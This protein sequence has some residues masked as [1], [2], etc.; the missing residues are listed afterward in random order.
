MCLQVEVLLFL[1]KQDKDLLIKQHLDKLMVSREKAR[2]I[3]A[4]GHRIKSKTNENTLEA[5][6]YLL[7]E[8]EQGQLMW[9]ERKSIRYGEKQMNSR[10][11][12]TQL[13]RAW[14]VSFWIGFYNECSG[15]AL[16]DFQKRVDMICCMHLKDNSSYC[17]GRQ[18]S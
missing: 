15:K 4:E 18:R 12:M 13:H 1:M 10:G 11:N 6:I 9:V 14:Q 3:L 2:R 16:E 8:K 5:G 7:L 17:V